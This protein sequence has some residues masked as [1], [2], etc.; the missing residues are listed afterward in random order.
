M[1]DENSTAV[2]SENE[3]TEQE[4]Q[5]GTEQDDLE[6]IDEEIA[7]DGERA[8]KKIRKLNSEIRG[9]KKQREQDASRDTAGSDE[10]DSRIKALEAENLRIRIGAKH[11]LPEEL[12]ERLRGDDEEQILADAEK[13]LALVSTR[14]PP[15]AK[16]TERLR[17]GGD[18]VQEPEETD[19]S[20]LGERMFRH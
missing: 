17:G 16:P 5:E 11:G 15:T 19:V 6:E 12:I 3:E 7:W 1:A 2:E 8:L 4:P 13:L 20:K 18:P 9:L 10:K 14:R